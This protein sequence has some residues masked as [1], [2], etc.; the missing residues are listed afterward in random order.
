MRFLGKFAGVLALIALFII[1]LFWAFASFVERKMDGPDPVTIANGSLQGLREQSRLSAFAARYVAVVT[2]TQSQFGLSTKKTLI[3]PGDVRYEVDLGKLEQKDVT[4]DAKQR[5]LGVTL[6]PIEVYGPQ[7]DLTAIR[8]YGEGGVLTVITDAEAKL[9]AA[10][11]KAGQQELVKQARAP[12]PMK[13][14]R[15]A[16]RRAVERSFALP[17]QAAGIS[18]RVEVRF[19]DEGV[20]STERWDTSRS[21]AEVL[22][23][24]R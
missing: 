1:G 9:D 16:T 21:L 7:V 13:L 18:A 6:P 14:A 4:W 10:N 15:D 17:L 3:M 24:A 19:A 20:R 12:M 11:R 23:N 2:S 22:G 8:E 5:L